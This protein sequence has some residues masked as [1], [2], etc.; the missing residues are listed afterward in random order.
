MRSTPSSK[1]TTKDACKFVPHLNH[2]SAKP[3]IEL[4]AEYGD[5]AV[6]VSSIRLEHVDLAICDGETKGIMKVVYKKKNG[7][8]LG[9]TMMSPSG[10]ELIS[11][12]CVAMKAKMPFDALA[13]VIHP[14]PSYAIALQMLAADVYY[15]KTMKLKW[16]YDLLKKIGL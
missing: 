13:K 3:A 11:E 5:D 1:W 16:L 12:I 15:E 14:Y 2:A 9:A 7:Q 8:I 6:A 10:G 4:G